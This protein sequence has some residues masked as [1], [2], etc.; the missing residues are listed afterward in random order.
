MDAKTLSL[1][2]DGY[3]RVAISWQGGPGMHI[4][5]LEYD[6]EYG[7]AGHVWADAARDID[8]GVRA[9]GGFLI[10]LGNPDVYNPRL[11]EVYS[12]P[13]D[14]V[15]EDGTVRLIVEAEITPANC[16]KEIVGR[17]IQLSGQGGLSTMNIALVMPDCG[18]GGGYLVLKN[19][20]QDLKIARN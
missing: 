13:F 5:A 6:A 12:F 19:L 7:D 9:E 4:H 2:I 16:G 3:D 8:A 10:Q 11:A 18:E 15:P 14:R 17:T 20:L 1:M